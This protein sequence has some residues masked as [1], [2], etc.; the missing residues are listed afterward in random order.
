MNHNDQVHESD[1]RGIGQ[2][3]Y[4][5]DGL[6]ETL[7]GRGLVLIL[8]SSDGRYA[9]QLSYTNDI[10]IFGYELVRSEGMKL[11]RFLGQVYPG[12]GDPSDWRDQGRC[13]ILVKKHLRL[14]LKANTPDGSSK[15]IKFPHIK[16][17]E[18][19]EYTE[20]YRQWYLYRY[21]G[22]LK[23]VI[24][25]PDRT[26]VRI[27]RYTDLSWKWAR[28]FGQGDV[29]EDEPGDDWGDE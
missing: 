17:E 22:D 6:Y 16:F 20:F 21:K 12:P 13:G 4:H 3:H 18:P 1:N 9:I 23:E 10:P 5:P 14:Y 25:C 11:G 27:Q 7:D 2:A 15:L 28:D 26:A 19:S 24:Y 29:D 8:T